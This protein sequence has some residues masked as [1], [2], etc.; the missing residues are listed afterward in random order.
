MSE[1]VYTVE[2]RN[3]VNRQ[4][5]SLLIESMFD[6]NEKNNRGGDKGWSCLLWLLM[7]NFRENDKNIKEGRK[8]KQFFGRKTKCWHSEEAP[9]TQSWSLGTDPSTSTKSH[10]TDMREIS[11]WLKEW[12]IIFRS[13][14]KGQDRLHSKTQQE[15][16]KHGLG[17]NTVGNASTF[18]PALNPPTSRLLM[19][20]SDQFAWHNIRNTHHW[21]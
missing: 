2:G 15:K 20:Q 16:Q 11:V 18:S 21:R 12:K 9:W 19:M 14:T 3:R 1:D 5:K 8:F 17:I 13:V 7:L 6:R 10:Y 4:N